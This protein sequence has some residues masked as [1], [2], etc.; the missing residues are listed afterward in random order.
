LGKFKTSISGG[1]ASAEFSLGTPFY[2]MPKELGK[3]DTPLAKL[4]TDEDKLLEKLAEFTYLESKSF[5]PSEGRADPF[6]Y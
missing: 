6:S 3:I 5:T 4:T 1:N 2:P